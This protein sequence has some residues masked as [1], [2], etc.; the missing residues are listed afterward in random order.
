MRRSRIQLAAH[1][2]Q[3]LD[4]ISPCISSLPIGTGIAPRSTN[5][6]G[7]KGKEMKI[8]IKKYERFIPWAW[9]GVLI[10]IV[11]LFVKNALAH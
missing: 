1:A 4:V 6:G 7:F 5:N 2:A 9:G 10:A 8:E 3:N 11:V